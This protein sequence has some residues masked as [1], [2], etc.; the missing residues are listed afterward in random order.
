MQSSAFGWSS[1]DVLCLYFPWGNVVTGDVHYQ[2]VTP[3][4]KLG[5]LSTGSIRIWEGG[6][7]CVPLK[8]SIYSIHYEIRVE[9]NICNM[10]ARIVG[11]IKQ[12]TGARAQRYS[13]IAYQWGARCRESPPLLAR[14]LWAGSGRGWGW[15]HYPA[16]QL[17]HCRTTPAHKINRIN[18]RVSRIW[19]W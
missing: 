4:P 6:G 3:F 9:K 5:V 14:W 1:P 7:H 13:S 19:H 15:A 18:L 16:Q 8:L 17:H 10:N 11:S 2:P 12:T